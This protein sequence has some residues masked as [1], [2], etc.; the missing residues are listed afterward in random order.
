MPIIS[1][2]LLTSTDFSLLT[3]VKGATATQ[4]MLQLQ[5]SDSDC[6]VNSLICLTNMRNTMQHAWTTSCNGCL[7]FHAMAAH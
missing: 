6:D 3:S 7:L 2:M 5:V 1:C 4:I